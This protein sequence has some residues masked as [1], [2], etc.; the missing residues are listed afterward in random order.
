[1]NICFFGFLRRNI[2][3]AEQCNAKIENLGKKHVKKLIKDLFD[4]ANTMSKL[5]LASAKNY[6][7][8]KHLE[9]L[10]QQEQ[11]GKDT[12]RFDNEITAVFDKELQCKCITK[13]Q[14]KI[15]LTSFTL[16]ELLCHL[17]IIWL[18]DSFSNVRKFFLLLHNQNL[19][20]TEQMNNSTRICQDRIQLF[21]DS[22]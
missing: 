16:I 19:V 9:L 21:W 13:T 2:T 10:K 11:S 15:I 18:C 8:K 12:N 3:P 22:F 4:F 5:L 6:H 17:K 7:P 20:Q 1:M 14:Q